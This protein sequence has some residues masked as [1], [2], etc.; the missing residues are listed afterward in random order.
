MQIIGQDRLLSEID[1]YIS[2]NCFP[3]STMIMGEVGSGRH[4]IAKYIAGKLNVEYVDITD[5]VGLDDIINVTLSP[6]QHLVV[7]DISAIDERK[8]NSIL[9]FVEEPPEYDYILLIASSSGNILQTLKNRCIHLYVDKYSKNSLSE[10]IPEDCQNKEFILEYANTPGDVIDYLKYNSTEINDLNRLVEN[11]ATK[12]EN[13]PTYNVLN[14][15][16]KIKLKK[17]SAGYDANLFFKMLI[18]KYV[19]QMKENPVENIIG[20]ILLTN[21]YYSAFSNSM[22][23]KEY[24]FDNF[25]LALKEGRHK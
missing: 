20:K 9:K 5:T 3:K 7:I 24:L 17:D 23:N 11:V 15:S 2:G 25:L 22:Y 18:S 10:F 6:T 1:S 19:M 12:I 8:A 4:T 14:I 16:S 21:E 13:A